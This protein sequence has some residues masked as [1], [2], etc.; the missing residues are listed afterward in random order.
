M[1][2]HDSGREADAFRGLPRGRNSRMRIPVLRS[3]RA[4]METHRSGRE[5]DAFRG[6]PRGRNS[7]MRIPVLRSHLV[8]AV[9]VV[10]LLT[11]AGDETEAPDVQLP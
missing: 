3:S 11:D 2:T 5:A 7:R 6:L 8:L 9:E 4:L 10:E 1:E